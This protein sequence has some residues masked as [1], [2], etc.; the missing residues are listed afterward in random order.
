MIAIIAILAAILFPV[1]ARA[2]ENARRSS[3]Q[4]NLKQLGLGMLQYTQDYDEFYPLKD[5]RIGPPP[6][7]F[8]SFRQVLQPYIKSTQV[9][10]CPSNPRNIV[11]ADSAVGNYPVTMTSYGMS[12]SGIVDYGGLYRNGNLPVGL[13]EIPAPAQVIAAA[14]TT[15]NGSEYDVF[16]NILNGG[17]V[18]APQ[19]F[20]GHLGTS[21][22]LFVDGHV[23]SMRPLQTM[24]ECNPNPTPC[25]S[26]R[27][28]LWTRDNRNP[29]V[30]Y[31][32][33]IIGDLTSVQ[34]KYN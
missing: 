27:I 8:A 6:A 14:E 21:N 7:P 12:G 20:A 31:Y 1:F 29:S 26:S 22:Y 33:N 2:R 28:N 11:P 9:M 24:P 19:L 16:N 15:Y 30:G 18:I 23:K 4:S 17:N 25:G 10:V 34:N 32:N 5:Q 13:A 3:C